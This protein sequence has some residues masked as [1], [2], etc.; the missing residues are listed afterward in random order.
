MYYNDI[1]FLSEKLNSSRCNNKCG[2]TAFYPRP[3]SLVN[4]NK[5]TIIFSSP[6]YKTSKISIKLLER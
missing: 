1:I 5:F 4:S 3:Y 6:L 2:L